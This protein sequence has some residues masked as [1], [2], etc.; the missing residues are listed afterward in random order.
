VSATTKQVPS[1][2]SNISVDIGRDV[3]HLVG[4]DPRGAI[5]FRRKIKR[6]TL[7]ATF[8]TL[9]RCIVGQEECVSA[10]LVSRTLRRL[11]FDPRI[12]PAKHT[13][14]FVKGRKNCPLRAHALAR[15]NSR[16]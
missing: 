4:F 5:V 10:H 7:V 12:I 16:L 6:L 14:S 3:F 2:L 1:E 13:K 11:G 15:N 9:P 8:A